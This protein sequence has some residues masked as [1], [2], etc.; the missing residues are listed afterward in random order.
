M[1]QRF[2]K[3]ARPGLVIRDPDHD[4]IRIA[5]GGQWVLWGPYWARRMSD[6]D[7]I[8]ATPPPEESESVPENAQ[9]ASSSRRR[10]KE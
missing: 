5:E 8:E 2:L 4:G 10:S 9:A 3:P 7:V 6:G 1:S